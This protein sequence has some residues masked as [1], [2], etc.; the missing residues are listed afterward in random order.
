MR[1][2]D[3]PRLAR[4][5]WRTAAAWILGVAVVVSAA[6]LLLDGGRPAIAA[7][8]CQYGPYQPYEPYE[9]YGGDC[10][11]A[12][13]SL[14]TF[15]QPSDAELGWYVFDAAELSGGRSPSGALV[16]RLFAPGD[17]SCTS[18]VSV[19]TVPVSG[20]RTY[21]SWESGFYPQLD[22][23]GTWRWTVAYSGDAANRPA[24]SGCAEE[25]VTVRIRT[26]Y[27]SLFVSVAVVPVGSS[28][29]AWVFAGGFQPTG[30]IAV[31]LF[32]PDDPGCAGAPA[33]SQD[34]PFNGQSSMS[35]LVSLGPADAVG[36]WRW[37]LDYSGD[38]NNT[39]A[40]VACDTADVDVVKA[41]PSLS[42]GPSQRSAVVGTEA[43]FEVSLQ[44]GFL[45]TG[46]IALQLYR[47]DDL[48][49]STPV[50]S[51]VVPVDGPGPYSASFVP[52]SVGRW[53]VTATYSGDALNART[54]LG[55]S[56]LLLDATKATP[57]L[58][59]VSIPTT[60]VV[61]DVLGAWLLVN[62]GYHPTGRVLFRLF[63]RDDSSCGGFPVHVEEA[64]LSG[65][66]SST[67]T[68]FSVPRDEEGTW[69][70]TATYL[71]DDDNEPVTT[72]C[73][74]APVSVVANGPAPE[75]SAA[76]LFE[77]HVHFDC[78]A[79][80]AIGVPLGSRLV[81]RFAFATATERQIRQ[82]L[83][84]IETRLVVDGEAVSG[85]GRFWG[86]PFQTDTGWTARWRYD[87]GRAV[88]QGTQAFAIEFAVVA[89]KAGADGSG[90]WQQ[91][92]VLGTSGG[93]CLVD[94]LQP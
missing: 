64:P 63:D 25:P 28:L 89:T 88:L 18:P 13:P 67:P 9:Q 78:V 50:D 66:T 29:D 83:A 51:Q 37:T 71:G 91:G 38:A 73:G 82:F 59:P 4:G 62:G 72:A 45:P 86:K 92:D 14:R 33:F 80:H 32:G 90:T 61:G 70:W 19:A 16:F 81:L 40:N 3:D 46:T 44:N 47:P 11:Q 93:I 43:S 31:R 36:R 27:A 79:D 65:G 24:T 39:A 56:S 68:G 8:G 30:S 7:G 53:R 77:A 41:S 12:Q 6:S 21:Y 84:G 52:T 1:P 57:A 60:A 85:S 23:V 5:P 54:G 55:C 49:C 42:A 75:P 35:Q 2:T 94:G 26:T 69:N 34:I 48:G 58:R 17:P 76:P 15:P 20:N 74:Q 10:D 22:Q 87:T